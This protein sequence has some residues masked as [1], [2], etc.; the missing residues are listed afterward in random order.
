MFLFNGAKAY[1]Q[2][3]YHII[4]DNITLH[5]DQAKQ[6]KILRHQNQ[7]YADYI[8]NIAPMLTQYRNLK[9]FQMLNTPHMIFARTISYANLPDISSIYIDYYDANF[10]IP[11]GLVYNNQAAGI[12]IKSI[13]NFA[14][15]YL[16]NNPKT[17]YTVFIG[18]SKIP[19]VVFGGR[20]M[21][22][23]Y[24]PKYHAISQGD[25][26]V[27]SGLDN[28][29]YEGVKVGVVK[30]VIQKD[31]YQE[32]IIKPFYNYL[33]PDYFYVTRIRK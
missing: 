26:V 2:K 18:K 1:A 15:A 10:T 5:F 22:V 16:N 3:Y 23:K 11:Q 32:A 4:Y 19:G 25:L 27:T 29:F 30:K 20:N 7:E 13:K 31:L 14:L 21:V 17:S 12:V 9:N 33:H 28:I 24:I 6:I 8:A